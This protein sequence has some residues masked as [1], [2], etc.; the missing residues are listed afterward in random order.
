MSKRFVHKGAGQQI[1]NRGRQAYE[2]RE[3]DKASGEK[4]L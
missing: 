4:D 3:E 2:S 1:H